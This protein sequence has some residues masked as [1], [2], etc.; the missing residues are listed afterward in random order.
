MA[1]GGMTAEWFRDETGV[2]RETLA[3]LEVYAETLV[4]WQARINLV[5]A[6]TLPDLWRR[7]FLDSAQLRAHIPAEAALLDLGT[8]PGFPG[9]VLAIMGQA[10]T[11]LVES[12]QRKAAFLREVARRTET[13]VH[14]RNTRVE[15]IDPWPVD[16]VTARALAP[17]PKLLDYAFPFVEMGARLVFLKGKNVR[18]ELTEAQKTWHM[19]YVLERSRIDNAGWVLKIGE[20]QRA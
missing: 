18:E 16:V 11:T 10:T 6:A 2:S 19:S 13:P 5:G 20:M 8:G 15:K 9:L 4:K 12:D 7:H 14:I 1:Q 17:L 3:L